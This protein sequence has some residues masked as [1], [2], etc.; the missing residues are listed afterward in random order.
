M[1]APPLPGGSHHPRWI[2]IDKMSRYIVWRAHTL[3]M[4]IQ[5][6]P[7]LRETSYHLLTFPPTYIFRIEFNS[8]AFDSQ[9]FPKPFRLSF[10]VNDVCRRVRSFVQRWKSGPDHPGRRLRGNNLDKWERHPYFIL[11]LQFMPQWD[12]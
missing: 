2:I 12:L 7:R 6:N 1:C 3:R 8:I 4:I 5:S 9:D 10:L 11:L